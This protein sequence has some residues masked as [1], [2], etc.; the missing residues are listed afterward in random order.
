MAMATTVRAPA[1]IRNRRSI[2]V[3]LFH[4]GTYEEERDY[5]FSIKNLSFC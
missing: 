5:F 4:H 2:L 1:K 3:L